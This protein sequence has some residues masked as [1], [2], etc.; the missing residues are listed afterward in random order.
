MAKTSTPIRRT[1]PQR[2]WCAH[3]NCQDAIEPGETYE[4]IA[5]ERYHLECAEI[6]RAEGKV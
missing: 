4:V 6:A 1:S 2:S 5:R 3:P